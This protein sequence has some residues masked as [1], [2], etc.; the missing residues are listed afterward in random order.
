M[1]ASA[2]ISKVEKTQA[3]PGRIIAMLLAFVAGASYGVA[4]AVSRLVAQQGF[5]VS[6]IVVAQTWSAVIMLGILVLV[7]FRPHMKAKEILQL[8][9][10]GCLLILSGYCYYTAISML[11]VG[12]AVA[13]QFQYVWLVV[14]IAAIVDRKRPTKWVVLSSVLIVFGT[15]FASGMADEVIDNGGLR[16]NPVGLLVAACCAMSYSLFIFLNGKVAVEHHP[17]TRSFFMMVGGVV[18]ASALCPGFY[19]GECDVFAIIPGGIAM[20]LISSVVPCICLAASSSKLPGGLVAIL[21]SSELPF[22]VLA[23]FLMFGEAVTPLVSFGVVL[24]LC[25]I[26]LSEMGSFTKRRRP[27]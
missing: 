16:M 19:L 27:A 26:A 22:A 9:G 3:K 10:V 23:G 21:T 25:A 1:T 7:K 24:I 20:G 14:V 2:S 12:T 11:T 15:L 17:V 18:L 5:T 8:M 13:I 6:Q 4:G